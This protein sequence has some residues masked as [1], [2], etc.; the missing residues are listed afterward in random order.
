MSQV[1]AKMEVGDTMHMKGP[2]GRMT[3]KPN[4]KQ[5]IGG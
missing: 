5:H 1:I 2:K 3:Y 4:M